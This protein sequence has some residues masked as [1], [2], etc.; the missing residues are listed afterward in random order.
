M[1]FPATFPTRN[2]CFVSMYTVHQHNENFSM[3][4]ALLP[5][6]Q[7]NLGNY[8]PQC[9]FSPYFVRPYMQRTGTYFAIF[10][11]SG[12]HF[13]VQ[14]TISFLHFSTHS[15]LVA[16]HFFP[17]CPLSGPAHLPASKCPFQIQLPLQAPW[18][19]QGHQLPQSIVPVLHDL[20]FPG[21]LSCLGSSN[22][23]FWSCVILIIIF[24]SVTS[25]S[26]FSFLQQTAVSACFFLSAS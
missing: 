20:L 21:L 24:K 12:L 14:W 16:P 26:P 9:I 15:S 5:A 22:L 11:S 25:L 4:S 13:V 8:Q 23:F 3:P 7:P 10:H 1:Q 17:E 2:L 19:Q 18:L 6:F